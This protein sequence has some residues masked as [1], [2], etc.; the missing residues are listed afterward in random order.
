[1]VDEAFLYGE[2]EICAVGAQCLSLQCSSLFQCAGFDGNADGIGCICTDDDDCESGYCTWQ[3]VCAE[4]LEIGDTGCT[5]DDDCASG[6][7]GVGESLPP[8]E[9]KALGGEGASCIYDAQC[10]SNDCS[11]SGCTGAIP[12]A[13]PTPAPPCTLGDDCGDGLYCGIN[14]DNFNV[15][16]PTTCKPKQDLGSVCAIDVG[17]VSG[18]CGFSSLL[19]PICCIEGEAAPTASPT[20]SPTMSPMA[21]PSI[22]P[23][24]PKLNLG[25]LCFLDSEC[26]SGNCGYSS[27]TCPMCCIEG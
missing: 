1:M 22:G 18:S 20:L 10:A 19:C 12:T 21:S 3:L 26:A 14:T 13:S 24:Q 2:C 16:E 9:C 15:N 17:C 11:W 5:E 8:F 4:K 7:C 25:S 6:Y 23:T 27:W